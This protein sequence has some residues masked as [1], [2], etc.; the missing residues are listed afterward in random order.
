MSLAGKNAIVTGAASGLG[1][2]TS[3][4]LAR[5]GAAVAVWDIDEA[6][7]QRAAS[8]IVAS[9]GRAI[10]SRVDVSSRAQID[11]G[12]QR[13]HAELGPVTIL[14]NNAG[15]T[16][17]VPFLE[18]TEE[19]WDR[20]MMVNLK[21]MFMAAQA[22]LPDMLAAGWGRIINISSSSAQTG[23]TRM[24]HYASSKG[25]VIAFTKSLAVEFA[26]QGITVNNVPPGFVDTPMLRASEA[27][28]SAGSIEKTAA[29]SPMKRPGRP[30]D[31]AAACAFLA[32]EDA[33]YI[34]GHTLS[35]NGGR[36]SS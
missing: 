1:L 33:G 36:Y 13:A 19:A 4:R 20:M 28:V 16:G 9:G 29:A 35:V 34:T 12:V 7:A 11:A 30:E 25:G 17:F 10:A 2:A 3:K 31:I 18:I 21:S 15:M 8:D 27:L 32:S 22:V 5:D 26:A 24:A 23:A 6:G 14:V